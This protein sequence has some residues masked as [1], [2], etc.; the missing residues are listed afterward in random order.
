MTTPAT[1]NRA[2]WDDWASAYGADLRATTKCH[3]IK[4]LELD[5]ISRRLDALGGSQTLLE[6]GCGNGFNGLALV[7]RHEDLRYMGLDFSPE[8]VGHAV[9]AVA[10]AR[11]AAPRMAVG[12]GDGRSL[13]AP[14][15]IDAEGPAHVGAEWEDLLPV[16]S[17]DVVLTNRMLINLA[18]AQEQLE[19]MR[20]IKSV[21][22]PG[23]VFLMLE[24]SVQTHARLNSV[25]EALG[26]P[27]RPAAEF[28][29]F[30]DE[31]SVIKPF[32][33][34][35]ALRDVEDFGAVHDLLLYAVEPTLGDGEVHYDSP[36]LTTVTDALVTLGRVAGQH[37]PFG[38]NRLW[39]WERA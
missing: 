33:A 11:P 5:A 6:V 23:G 27:A 37:L 35:M 34:D 28:N 14:L 24:N 4:R 8:M 21:L 9:E 17:V 29:I 19:T 3:S 7:S 13:A 38:Q 25:R 2:H 15:M 18:S 22:R 31:P 16:E 20:R 10:T 39:V 12:V 26:L 1:T 36:L 30:I 32:E